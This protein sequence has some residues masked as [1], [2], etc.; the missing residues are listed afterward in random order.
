M[1]LLQAVL[2]DMDGTALRQKDK[3]D[4]TWRR[5]FGAAGFSEE[6]N[7]LVRKYQN[8][9]TNCI[10][11][12]LFPEFHARHCA[13]L[14]GL[15]VVPVM[16]AFAQLPY[17]PGFLDFCHYLQGQGV[18]T[19]LATLSIDAVAQLIK[20]EAGLDMVLANELHA[21]EGLF[22]GTG[23]ITV[24]F[25]GKGKAVEK[26]YTALGATRETTAFFGDSG[27]DVEGWQAVAY[28]LG[29]NAGKYSHLLKNNFTDF[30]EA[31][32][33]FQKE[34]FNIFRPRPPE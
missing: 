5:F 11:S 22:T 1:K 9:D 13:L 18:K 30:F 19:G 3:D 33:Y 23:L 7:E 16:E 21:E 29:I 12:E 28:P 4:D 34:F 10:P 6:C 14:Q 32:E 25:G 24:P 20:N 31:K 2:F 8:P 15:S 17:T 27:N 26:I